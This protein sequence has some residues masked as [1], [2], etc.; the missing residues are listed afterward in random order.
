MCWHV[1]ASNGSEEY[2]HHDVLCRMCGW[3]KADGPVSH[4]RKHWNK[5]LREMPGFFRKENEN[6]GKRKRV[7]GGERDEREDSGK[8][9]EK[10]RANIFF[11]D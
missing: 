9:K 3:S 11:D 8:F 5:P 10:R 7:E 6:M 2:R 1:T 4:A